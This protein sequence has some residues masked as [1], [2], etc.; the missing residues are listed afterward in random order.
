MK[1]NEDEKKIIYD[2]LMRSASK[3]VYNKLV[4]Q[5]GTTRPT[6][7]KNFLGL[8]DYLLYTAAD[9]GKMFSVCIFQKVDTAE[10]DAYCFTYNSENGTIRMYKSDD[11]AEKDI[12]IMKKALAK[13][14]YANPLIRDVYFEKDDI[15]SVFLNVNPDVDK[16]V[17]AISTTCIGKE[18]GAPAQECGPTQECDAVKENEE[19]KEEKDALDELFEKLKSDEKAKKELERLFKII[20]A[21][22]KKTNSYEK[23]LNLINEKLLSKKK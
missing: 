5:L 14:G 6:I 2:R 22:Y 8:S 12:E 4:E 3:K 7:K 16:I 11:D 19:K 10:F 13:A 23:S 15:K 20:E 1:L 18:V 17:N 21:A 9:E